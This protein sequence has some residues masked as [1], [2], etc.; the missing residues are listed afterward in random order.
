MNDD[1]GGEKRCGAAQ[2]TSQQREGPVVMKD[3]DG[4]EKRC[5]A[6]HSTAQRSEARVS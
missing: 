3:D 2:G 4:D 1:D 6:A 5:E